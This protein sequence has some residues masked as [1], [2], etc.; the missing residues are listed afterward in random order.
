MLTLNTTAIEGST[1]IVTASFTDDD[2]AAVTPDTDVSW[3]LK[4][5]SSREEVSSGTATASSADVDIVIS[6][7]DLASGASTTGYHKME[8]IVSTTYS[9]DAGVG[10]PLEDV[11]IFKIYKS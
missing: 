4:K 3:S 2:S 11:L 1:F 7:S 8:L 5:S 10:L 6:G 9:S